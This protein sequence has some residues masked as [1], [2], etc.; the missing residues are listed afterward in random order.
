MHC[1]TGNCKVSAIAVSRISTNVENYV[2]VHV[3]CTPNK[4]YF[5]VSCSFAFQMVSAN[6]SDNSTI[7]CR[8]SWVQDMPY[9]EFAVY[10]CSKCFVQ[11]FWDKKDLT[12]M[13]PPTPPYILISIDGS[14][15]NMTTYYPDADSPNSNVCARA[16]SSEECQMW[17]SCCQAAKYCCMHTQ[18][19]DKA[20]KH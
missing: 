15:D 11:V 17:K 12:I 19:H 13:F 4:K 18:Q 5:N 7:Y 9:E 8:D 16:L 1:K 14:P 2:H 6:N 3:K 10:S 20:G